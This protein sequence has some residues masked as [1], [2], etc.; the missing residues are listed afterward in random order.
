MVEKLIFIYH[1]FL[2][3]ETSSIAECLGDSSV[4]Y[5]EGLNKRF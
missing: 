2:E 3:V 1:T 5:K 4:M